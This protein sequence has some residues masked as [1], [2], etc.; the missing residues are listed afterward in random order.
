M[1]LRS[2]YLSEPLIPS[3]G[4]GRLF[5]NNILALGQQLRDQWLYEL[6]LM[7][8]AVSIYQQMAS[9]RDYKVSG[10]IRGVTRCIE[11]MNEATTIQYDGIEFTGFDDFQKRRSVDHLTVGRTLMYTPPDGPL[12]YLDPTSTYF[13]F[14]KKVWYSTYTQEEF[15]A[16]NVHVNHAFPVGSNGSFMAPLMPV[17]SSGMLAYLIRDHDK[18]SVDGRR[19]RDVI[20]VQGKD[21]AEQAITA[22]EQMIKQYTE[23]DAT[24]HNVPVVH[25]EQ[26]GNSALSAKDIVGRIGLSEIPENFNRADFEFSYV[27]EI[28]AALGISLRHFWNSEKATNRALEE[29][30]EARQAQKGPSYFVRNEERIFNNKKIVKR[31][32][33]DVRVNFIEEV[34]VQSRETNAKVL[35]MYAEAV[36]LLNNLAPGRIDV[37]ALISFLQ[38]DEILPVDVELVMEG[39]PNSSVIKESDQETTPG[40]GNTVTE[41]NPGVQMQKSIELGQDEVTMDLNGRILERRRPT[42]SIEKALIKEYQEDPEF[43]KI[44]REEQEVITPDNL[45]AKAHRYNLEQ[46]LAADPDLREQV[47]ADQAVDIQERAKALTVDSDLSDN[48][49]RLIASLL[50]EI[51]AADEQ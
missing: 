23:P 35:K 36:G 22:M 16:A 43:Q 46:F 48:D 9:G 19:I 11:W 28:A 12:R 24:K 38:R 45:L 10:P 3:P 25:Y 2:R 50:M 39:K 37:K 32:G 20:I 26:N 34:D 29:V 49:N 30:Q 7:F 21:V 8:E 6:P 33:R 13:D 40:N 41:G 27:N 31:F 14:D 42:F 18:A 44:L 51:W 17:V 15:P 47:I 5:T 4:Y 1:A